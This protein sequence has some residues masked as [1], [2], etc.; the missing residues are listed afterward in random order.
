MVK[1]PLNVGHGC[2]RLAECTLGFLA[3]LPLGVERG[4]CGDATPCTV[5]RR[6]SGRRRACQV[7]NGDVAILNKACALMLADGAVGEL[8]SRYLRDFV[9][10]SAIRG[11]RQP[12]CPPGAS[13]GSLE[14]RSVF[15]RVQLPGGIRRQVRAICHASACQ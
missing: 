15:G 14:F 3:R 4:L 7:D 13:L 12:E 6:R 1:S 8:R 11:A 5:H 2:L 9:M 10:I